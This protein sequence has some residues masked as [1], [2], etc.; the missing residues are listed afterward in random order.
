MKVIVLGATSAIAEATARLYA[1]EGAEL[2]LVGRQRDRLEAIAADLRLRCAARVEI[3]TCDL[4]EAGTAM[5]SLAS[6]ATTL[7]GVEHV[8]IAYGTLG[9]QK[10]SESDLATAGANLAVNFISAACWALAAAE[11]LE[12]QGHGSLVVLGSVAGDRG[13]RANCV[14][15]AAKSGLGTLVEGIAHR[16]AAS[17]PRA[18]VVKSGPVITPMTEGFANRKGPLWATPVTVAAIVRRAAERGSPVVYAPRFWRWIM[19]IIGLLPARV[20]NRLNI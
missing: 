10:A 11:I 6:F 12:Q 13:R 14:Y 8:L 17:G 19:L 2:L 3:A 1:G 7:G 20:F 18:V 9:D 5:E 4:A 15:G 16:F